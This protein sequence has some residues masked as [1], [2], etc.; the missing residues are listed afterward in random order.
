MIYLQLLGVEVL[1]PP[2]DV[3]L[4]DPL[5]AELMYLNHPAE[6]DESNQSSGRQQRQGHLQRLFQSLQVLVLHA[7]VHHIQKDQRHLRTPLRTDSTLGYTA[8]CTCL[9]ECTYLSVSLTW[10]TYS[11]VEN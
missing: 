2:E 5:T 8:D 3:A 4:G 9:S 1:G 6:G 7:G 10:T 11:M